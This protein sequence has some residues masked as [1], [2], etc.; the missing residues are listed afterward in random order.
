MIFPKTYLVFDFET[1]GLHPK[2]AK[3]IEVAWCIVKD[4]ETVKSQRHFLD[5]GIDIP[6]DAFKVHG[7]TRE[8]IEAEEKQ[9]E[10][11]DILAELLHDIEQTG[12]CVTHNG[13]F[14]D[15]TMLAACLTIP[16]QPIQNLHYDTA[17]I[18]KGNNLG[19]SLAEGEAPSDY[20]K[21]VLN[22]H[23]PFRFNLK[24]AA[25]AYGIPAESQHRA[26]D[27]VLL[28]KKLYQKMCLA[29]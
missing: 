18:F 26:A 12:A 7:I 4:N 20:F 6:E 14:F 19:M 17:A 13:T 27:D 29:E 25:T 16:E 2:I 9:G 3:P 21:R 5:W 22:T 23:S 10:P 8:M 11:W 15:V 28:T 24:A 1:T